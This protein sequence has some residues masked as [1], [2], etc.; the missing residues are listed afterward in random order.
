MRSL[1]HAP[2]PGLGSARIGAAA[3]GCITMLAYIG[4]SGQAA[5]AA[6]RVAATPEAKLELVM[7]RLNMGIADAA[8][9]EGSGVISQ[10]KSF[11]RVIPP[12]QPGDKLRAE[13]TIETTVSLARTAPAA[14]LPKK[15]PVKEPSPFDQLEADEDAAVDNS[16]STLGPPIDEPT[17]DT[18]EEPTDNGATRR[19][20]AESRD[21]ITRKYELVYDGSRWDLPVQ[22]GDDDLVA[23]YLFQDA[24]KGQ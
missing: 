21:T 22:P 5:P 15:K 6:P 11:H 14:T 2:S 1:E 12:A 23:R 20:I 4:C 19:A 9:A 17:A 7:E 18:A 3:I 13:V 10:R 8:A 24:L 16:A